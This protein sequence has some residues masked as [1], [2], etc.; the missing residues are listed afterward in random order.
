MR[1]TLLILFLLA[2]RSTSAEASIKV[3]SVSFSN[4]SERLSSER[5]STEKKVSNWRGGIQG[6]FAYSLAPISNRLSAEEASYQKGVKKGFSVGADLGYYF[7]KRTGLGLKYNQFRSW[8]HNPVRKDNV[9]MQF[10]GPSVFRRVQMSGKK[11]SLVTGFLLGYQ[12]YT[13]S[14]R[15]ELQ[16]FTLKGNSLGW[17]IDL[18]LD[19][20]LSDNYAL[21]FGA[22][23]FLGAVYKFKKESTAGVETI[24][25]PNDKYENLSRVELTLALRFQK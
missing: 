12:S 18:S 13:N 8:N 11:N 25:L 19:H 3:D 7:W 21:G 6:G 16:N 1:N 15:E 17:G 22:T 4:T 5:Y 2:V 9:T 14:R 20:K 10:I 24:Q 23:C